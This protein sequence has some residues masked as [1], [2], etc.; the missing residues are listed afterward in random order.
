MGARC[1]HR[2]LGEQGLI[3]DLLGINQAGFRLIAVVRR[4]LHDRFPGSVLDRYQWKAVARLDR[5]SEVMVLLDI[6][7]NQQLLSAGTDRITKRLLG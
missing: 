1:V 5:Q 3:T 2:D 6:K 4:G 7:R